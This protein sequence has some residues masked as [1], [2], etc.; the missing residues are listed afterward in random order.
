MFKYTRQSLN[1]VEEIFKEMSFK[2]L[3]EKGNFQSGYCI[4]DNK[5]II[6]INKFFDIEGRINVLV[7]IIEKLNIQEAGLSENNVQTLRKLRKLNVKTDQVEKV[8]VD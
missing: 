3:Y 2:I 1:K 6:V 5:D 4:V 8:E 7:E